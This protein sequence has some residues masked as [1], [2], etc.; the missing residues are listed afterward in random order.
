[1][2][3]CSCYGGIDPGPDVVLGCG[4]GGGGGGGA[5]EILTRI[6][7]SRVQILRWV[8]LFQDLRRFSYK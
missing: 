2:F 6:A 5:I 7:C 1:M 8:N 4:G 3:W